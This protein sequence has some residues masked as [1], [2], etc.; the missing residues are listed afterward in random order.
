MSKKSLI[1]LLIVSLLGLSLAVYI[2]KISTETKYKLTIYARDQINGTP[3]KSIP[4]EIV[5]IIDSTEKVVVSKKTNK[6]GITIFN[7]PRGKYRCGVQEGFKKNSSPYFGV[8]TIDLKED[9]KIDLKIL[10]MLP[11]VGE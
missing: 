11:P 9:A 5:R 1:A 10:K 8:E 4:I 3:M 7:L 6:D 2:M